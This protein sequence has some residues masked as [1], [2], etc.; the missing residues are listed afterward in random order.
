MELIEVVSEL[1]F[2]TVDILIPR[3]QKRRTVL[4]GSAQD[5]RRKT[6]REQ[7]PPASAAEVVQHLLQPT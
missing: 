5:E 1:K 4:D 3:R 2:C 6:A 7:A